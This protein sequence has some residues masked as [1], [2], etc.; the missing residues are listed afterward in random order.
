MSSLVIQCPNCHVRH[1][2]AA[3]PPVGTPLRCNNCG[4]EFRTQAEAGPQP[5]LFGGHDPFAQMPAAHDPLAQFPASSSQFGGPAI[6]KPSWESNS[7]SDLW[8]YALAGG[9]GVVVVMFLAIGVSMLVNGSRSTPAV[10]TAPT[11]APTVPAPAVPA[12]AASPSTP[13]AMPAAPPASATSPTSA[14]PIPSVSSQPT[15]SY[16]TAKPVSNVPSAGSPSAGSPTAERIRQLKPVETKAAFLY[17]WKTGEKYRYG[18]QV[19]TEGAESGSG[20]KIGTVEYEVSP[21]P[22]SEPGKE[23]E[24]AKQKGSGTGFVVHS[25]GLLMTCNHV[26][27]GA[28]SLKVQLNGQSY[29]AEVVAVDKPNDL[30]II[31]INATGLTALPLANSDL[32]QLAEDVSAFGYPL[33][34][35]L[36]AQM[37]V[38]L[39]AISGL[40]DGAEGSPLQVDITINAGNSGGPLVNRRGE[41]VGVN[42]AGLFGS[43][44]QE[45][46]FAVPSNLGKKLLDSIGIQGPASSSAAQLEKTEVARKVTPSVAFVEVELGSESAVL[47]QFTGSSKSIGS[48][49]L[50]PQQITSRV[51]AGL[52][53]EVRGAQQDLPIG[54]GLDTFGTMVLEKLPTD[55]EK[56]WEDKQVMPLSMAGATGGGQQVISILLEQ[57]VNYELKSV[58]EEKIVIAKKFAVATIG[59][60]SMGTVKVTGDG[61]W[62][63]DRK[64]GVPQ[65]MEMTID[66]YVSLGGKTDAY[67]GTVR[68]ERLSSDSPSPWQAELEKELASAA[69]GAAEDDSG[70]PPLPELPP[71]SLEPS[72]D[73]QVTSALRVLRAK[74]KSIVEYGEALELLSRMKPI[75]KRRDDVANVLH[76]LRTTMSPYMVPW[77]LAARVWATEKNVPTLLYT[78]ES[79]TSNIGERALAMET[80]ARVPA[81]KESATVIVRWVSDPTLGSSAVL[82]LNTMGSKAEEPIASLL[83]QSKQER[84]FGCVLLAKVGTSKSVPVLENYLRSE[85]DAQCRAIGDAALRALRKKAAAEKTGSQAK[86][87]TARSDKK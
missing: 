27:A 51:A 65:K 55:G 5:S 43:S 7:E 63:F 74:K 15:G 35:V 42:S 23:G 49:T 38:T 10:A 57:K 77:L 4:H 62:T 82:A 61:T 60:S 50:P 28:S 56:Q 76:N 71:L 37:K 68:Y 11:A 67:K 45:V 73:A 32:V 44:I 30:A 84:I 54:F 64:A 13:A 29:P 6:K 36:G 70:L 20:G 9:I 26:V 78:L 3:I 72:T 53:G 59:Q 66:S 33:S 41:V 1:P 22:G 2:V 46:S 86:S 34:D 18:F 83:K 25:D 31:R 12:P 87:D 8:K 58:D 14:A 39:G 69:T 16:S 19:K 40:S 21:F 47:L 48:T 17:N 81:T 24:G 52:T 79:P 75:E 85:S 80:L